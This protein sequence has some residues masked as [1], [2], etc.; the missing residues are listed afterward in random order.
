M[1]SPKLPRSEEETE[2]N[3]LLINATGEVVNTMRAHDSSKRGDAEK[4]LHA[5]NAPMHEAVM[6]DEVA[7]RKRRHAY[8]NAEHDFTEQTGV[9]ATP[10]EDARDRDGR[11]S[12]GEHVVQLEARPL[13][14]LNNMMRAMNR[15]QPSMPHRAVKESSPGVHR[16]R[17]NDGD[18]NPDGCMNEDR[19][20]SHS[21]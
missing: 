19:G 12:H 9:R 15:P 10:V 14:F 7:N 11:M 3:L 20:G 16:D 18:R 5:R 8:A 21:S 2:R 6:N 1:S 17:D 13:L 4:K